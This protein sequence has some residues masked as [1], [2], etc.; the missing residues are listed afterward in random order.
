MQRRQTQL[1]HLR[2]GLN[3]FNVVELCLSNPAKFRFLFVNEELAITYE[4]MLNLIEFDDCHTEDIA[5]MAD[6]W[7]KDYMRTRA[8]EKSGLHILL[9]YIDYYYSDW[10]RTFLYPGCFCLA[11]TI[12]SFVCDFWRTLDPPLNYMI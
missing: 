7:L 10:P 2:N 6:S 9:I 12:P 1:Q 5:M 4:T 11:S 3:H 8:I